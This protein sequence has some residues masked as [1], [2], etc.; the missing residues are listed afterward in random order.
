MSMPYAPQVE[1]LADYRY[2]SGELDLDPTAYELGWSN[3]R[4]TM[5]IR[6][7]Q[8]EGI[9]RL[10]RFKRY[11]NRDRPGMGKTMQAAFAAAISGNVS[12][13]TSGKGVKTLIVAPSYLTGT[14]YDWLLGKDDKSMR[15]NNGVRIPNVPGKVRRVHGS[16]EQR[17]KALRSNKWDWYI[18]NQEMMDSYRDIFIELQ[19][20]K[21][22][23]PKWQT[24]IVDESHHFRNHVANRVK[25][26][27]IVSIR[28]ERTYLLSATMLWKEVDDLYMPFRLIAPDE[29]KSYR[30]FLDLY[31]IADETR[32]GP[33]V[34]GVKTSMTGHL[35]Q[36]LNLM[37]I[38]RTYKE[39]GRELPQVLDNMIKI[40]FPPQLRQAYDDLCDYW[41]T[42]FLDFQ[43]TNFSQ[44]LNATRQMTFFPGKV[45]ASFEKIREHAHAGQKQVCFTWYGDHAEQTAEMFRKE[46][47]EAVAVT[48]KLYKD[49]E[50][51]KK[52]A[53]DPKNRIICAT[54]ASLS[55]G[56]DL[57]EARAVHFFEEHWPPGAN[58][59]ALSRIQRE[60]I[61]DDDGAPIMCYYYHVEG[62]ID[63]VIHD[64]AMARADVQQQLGLK[65]MIF[66][67]LR[68]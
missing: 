20:G 3:I 59:Q 8:L 15:R 31:C 9:N 60:R 61:Y 58:D 19:A 35:K 25:T 46:G 66:S 10:V 42:E 48:G 11:G 47:F 32:F 41:R 26:L 36:L 44:F 40:E 28:A 56:I 30:N 39:V 52:V 17:Y 21:G 51:R 2:E 38:G 65:E 54:I 16:R 37:T 7:Y 67:Y 63:N 14:W 4:S 24:V 6:P 29:F 62:T 49:P 13:E 33:K 5:R 45:E 12:D 53:L 1:E 22:T 68:I 55:E 23:P 27:E 64:R 50:E 43:V 57:S 34:L 18:V